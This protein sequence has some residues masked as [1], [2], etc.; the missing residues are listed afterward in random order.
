M[1]LGGMDAPRILQYPIGN[2]VADSIALR[3]YPIAVFISYMNYICCRP[4][5]NP[6]G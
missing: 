3:Q 6:I 1:V 5:R 2:T 4:I